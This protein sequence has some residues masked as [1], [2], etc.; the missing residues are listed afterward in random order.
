MVKVIDWPEVFSSYISDSLM[1][2]PHFLPKSA[3]N[4][5]A[6]QLQTD[7]VTNRWTDWPTEIASNLKGFHAK[8]FPDELTNF[9][10]ELARKLKPLRADGQT[11]GPTAKQTADGGTNGRTDGWIDWRTDGIFC[12]EKSKNSSILTWAAKPEMIPMSANFMNIQHCV[13]N[14]FFNYPLFEQAFA[15]LP[16]GIGKHLKMIITTLSLWLYF[17]FHVVH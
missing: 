4:L 11:D 3:R 2:L 7:R 13:L 9:W 6:L 17:T 10:P 12:V 16:F 14:S 1:V 8:V 15:P 5:K